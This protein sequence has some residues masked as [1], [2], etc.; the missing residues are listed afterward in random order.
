[1]KVYGVITD[2]EYLSNLC[3]LHLHSMMSRH[4]TETCFYFQVFI[5][6]TVS[7]IFENCVNCI[8]FKYANRASS[9][10]LVDMLI[11]SILIH[12]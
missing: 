1:M 5:Y 2:S 8:F 12:F 11:V 4:L 6:K 7:G 9:G 3:G 10:Y